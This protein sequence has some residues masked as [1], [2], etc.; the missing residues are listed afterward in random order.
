MTDPVALQARRQPRGLA[1]AGGEAR[2]WDQWDRE[3]DDAADRLARA[4]GGRLALRSP[5]RLELAALALGAVRAGA[6]GVLVPA[7]WPDAMASRALAEAG[8]AG[9][10]ARRDR[11]THRVAPT[12][13]ESGPSLAEMGR[14]SGA[15][16]VFTSGSTGAPRAALLTWDALLASAEGVVSHLGL[17]SGDGW[18][19]DLPVAHVGGL[20]VVVRCALAGAALVLPD[21][22]ARPTHA[23]LVSTQLRR[24]LDNSPA[25]AR[26]LRA[27]LLGGSAIPADLLDRAHGARLPIATS[28]G[29]TE[30]GSTVTATPVPASRTDLATSGR[31][32]PG[33]E[34]RIVDGEIHVRGAMRC[35]GFLTRDGLADLSGED[36][37]LATGDLGRFD[38]EGRLVVSGRL[39]LRFVSGGENV[40]PEAIEAALLAQP[41][42][43]EAVVVPVPDR[44][45]G[46]RP[47][48]FVRS[49]GGAPPDAAR[50]GSDLR[51]LLPGF[52]VPVAFHAWRGAEGMKPDRRS[53]SRLSETLAALARERGV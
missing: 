38:G 36:G 5:D 12:E 15:L 6:T 11:A 44:E 34:V 8:V 17:R 42:V 1:V 4:G 30:M 41:G 25:W 14:S 7:R 50:L 27:V 13:D 2:T 48:A 45:F 10:E 46:F 18:L 53:L 32:L 39:G 51:A 28:Y 24:L 19:L 37:W 52:M 23:S 35:A 49:V 9:A 16:A 3:I 21:A 20:G 31:V 43:A 47:V 40:Q 29:L 33:R 26:D 22:S